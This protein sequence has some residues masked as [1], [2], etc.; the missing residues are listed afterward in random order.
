MSLTFGQFKSAIRGR[1]WPPGSA[2]PDN[3]VASHDKDFVDALVDLQTWVPCLQQDNTDI[4]PQCSTTY[5]CGLTVLPGPRG[6]IKKLSV[7]DKIDPTT[8]RESA[9]GADDYCSE[10]VYPE[11]D[12][13][14]VRRYLDRSRR[15][16]CCG[17]IGLFFG[18]PFASHRP[19]YPVPT[20]VGLAPGLP[21][22]PMGF[23]YPQASTDRTHGRAGAGIWAKERGN[24]YVAPWIQST[25]TI[26]VVWD[27]IKRTWNDGDP[28]DDDPLLS[29]AVEEYVRFHDAGTWQHDWE[30]AASFEKAFIQTRQELIHQCREETRARDCEPSHARASTIGLSAIYYNDDQAFT[31]QC[32]QGQNGSPVT[33]TIQSGTVGS[34]VSVADANAKALAQATSQAKAQLVCSAIPTV[35]TSSKDF[36]Y[37]ATCATDGTQEAGAPTPVGPGVSVTVKAGTAFP[38]ATSQG[39]ADA[40]ALASAKAQAVNGL[41]CTYGNA[42]QTA[43]QACPDGVTGLVSITVHQN[44]HT[45]SFQEAA[46]QLA[47]ADAMKQATQKY[48]ENDVDCGTGTGPTIFWNTGPSQLV[49]GYAQLTCRAFGS[50]SSYIRVVVIMPANRFSGKTLLEANQNARNAANAWAMVIA[51]QRLLSI[52]PNLCGTVYTVTYPNQ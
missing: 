34:N 14:H 9:T 2:E 6:I 28:I 47:M 30:T 38:S 52:T 11:V 4:Y 12:Y 51:S 19:N 29:K 48:G 23:H 46:D 40:Q 13:C 39:D 18:L 26:I 31:A 17:G 3:L 27:G 50:L 36:T 22:L 45:A 7:I 10:I 24:I 49:N 8:N 44:A 15:G 25:E 1:V 43:T 20:D 32:P 37:N 33:V 5:N 21:P 16:G 42:P 35:Y 41:S